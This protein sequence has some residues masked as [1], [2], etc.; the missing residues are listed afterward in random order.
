MLKS[1]ALYSAL[2]YPFLSFEL[3]HFIKLHQANS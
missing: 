2:F 3:H 1:S